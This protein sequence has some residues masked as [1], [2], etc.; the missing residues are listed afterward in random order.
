MPPES[1]QQ[2]TPLNALA[3]R[4][5][6]RHLY[7]LVGLRTNVEVA[8][9]GANQ[10]IAFSPMWIEDADKLARILAG[11]PELSGPGHQP[12]AAG[13]TAVS[14]LGY[15]DCPQGWVCLW[16]RADFRDEDSHDSGRRLQFQSSVVRDLADCEFRDQ[17]TSVAN[18][19]QQGGARLVDARSWQPDPE[20]LIGAQQAVSNLAFVDYVHGGNWRNKADKIGI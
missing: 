16:D 5:N 13:D 6:L 11:A 1:E 15:S 10:V 2:T 17:T 7:G 12:A 9:L 19:R 18:K 8:T 4:D 20:L 14:P 3:V